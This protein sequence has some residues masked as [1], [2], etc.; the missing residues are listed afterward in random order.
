MLY[1]CRAF[2]LGNE[3]RSPD[4]PAAVSFYCCQTHS[5]T[6]IIGKA[7]LVKGAK[8]E[9]LPEMIT[10]SLSAS[11]VRWQGELVRAEKQ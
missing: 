7:S 10:I 5:A 9:Y 3:V 4:C 1:L 2:R 8:S 11:G 6:E